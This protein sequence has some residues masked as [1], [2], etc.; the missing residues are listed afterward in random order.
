MVAERTETFTSGGVPIDIEWFAANSNSSPKPAVLMLHGVDGLSLAERYR[1]GARLT[2]ASG[3]HVFFPHY[4]DRTGE[5]RASLPMV[6][7]HFT[8]WTETLQDAVTWLERHPGV[9]P[10]RIG[11]MGISLGA[12][13]ALA[14]AAED[15]RIRAL[16]DYF[17]PV[18]EGLAA[19]AR[20]LPPTLIL[21][22]EADPIVP[23]SHARTLESLLKRLRVPH[24]TA[25][26]PGQGHGFYGAAQADAG[27]RVGR[28]LARHLGM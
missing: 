23:V 3:Y 6:Y 7:R 16:V 8:T 10:K 18:P 2:A 28:F 12:S 13:L 21:H 15:A 22:G 5:N 19:R 11:V 27:R 24:E 14:A 4:F 26:Y 9:D 25:I 20:R 1:I 17:G